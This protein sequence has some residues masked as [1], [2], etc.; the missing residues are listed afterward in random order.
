MTT[1]M[2]GAYDGGRVLDCTEG[3][4]GPTAT[5]YLADFGA[6][7]LK[8]ETPT[9]DRLRDEP[10][11]LCWNRNKR[12]CRLD[13][14]DYRD[15]SELRRL[16][17]AADA[18]VFDWPAAELERPGLDATSLR[19]GRPGLTYAWMPPAGQRGRWAHLPAEPALLAAV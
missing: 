10:G 15:L 12:M 7:V 3:S 1:S 8:V 19:A 9:G 4:A 16:I 13:A 18:V 2:S 17:S 6:D 14:G 11:Y 5:M